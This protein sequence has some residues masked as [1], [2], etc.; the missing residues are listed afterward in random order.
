M[1][2]I[3]EDTCGAASTPAT[4]RGITLHRAPSSGRDRGVGAQVGA[5]HVGG[6]A[7]RHMPGVDPEVVG[8]GIADLG[9]EMRLHVPASGETLQE[10]VAT[11]FQ[12]GSMVVSLGFVVGFAVGKG[13]STSPPSSAP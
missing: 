8:G 11:G 6:F 5:D 9:T 7:Q 2:L 10:P 3:A 1:R 13:R 4:A 12:I